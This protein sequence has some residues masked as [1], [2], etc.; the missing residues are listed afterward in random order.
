MKVLRSK[1]IEKQG[2]DYTLGTVGYETELTDALG[3]TLKVGDVV[4]MTEEYFIKEIEESIKEDPHFPLLSEEEF[5]ELKRD[6]LKFV[7]KKSEMEGT[8]VTVITKH[9]EEGFCCAMGFANSVNDI[10]LSNIARAS[11]FIRK[12]NIELEDFL[13]SSNNSL[14]IYIDDI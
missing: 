12:R 8:R 3:N 13:D 10:N 9:A 4:E 7:L 1:Y 14:E 6:T 2:Y 5:E 11:K